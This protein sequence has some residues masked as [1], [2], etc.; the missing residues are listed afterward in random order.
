MVGSGND[1]SGQAS[2]L[3]SPPSFPSC[4]WY[5][6]YACTALRRV[7]HFACVNNQREGS[8][9]ACK[10]TAHFG[11]NNEADRQVGRG[12]GK[13]LHLRYQRLSVI[14]QCGPGPQPQPSNRTIVSTDFIVALTNRLPTYPHARPGTHSGHGHTAGDAHEAVQGHSAADGQFEA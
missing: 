3:P 2:C 9:F 12:R 14:I 1:N 8:A 4:C 7:V 13:G 10:Q 5:L 6:I 11:Q